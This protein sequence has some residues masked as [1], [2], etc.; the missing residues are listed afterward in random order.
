MVCGVIYIVAD[1]W[2]KCDSRDKLLEMPGEEEKSE[3]SFNHGLKCLQYTH[4]P[5]R[6]Y[7]YVFF[8]FCSC[9]LSFQFV[10]NSQIPLYLTKYSSKIKTY[11]MP[12]FKKQLYSL[13]T[14]NFVR[15]QM[16]AKLRTASE[17]STCAEH[18]LLKSF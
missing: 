4:L 14:R 3:T 5:L 18:L 17:Q 1:L 9:V 12:S 13:N 8:T 16:F 6:A 11:W 7:S 10:W 2:T 15:E